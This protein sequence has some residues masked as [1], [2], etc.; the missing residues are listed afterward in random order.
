MLS[1]GDG[2]NRLTVGAGGYAN[3]VRGDNGDDTVT[4]T[5]DARI[6]LLKLDGGNN[7]VTTANGNIESYYSYGG[8]NTL[9]IGNGGMQQAVLSGDGGVHQVTATGFVGSLQVYDSGTTTAN[10]MGGGDHHCFGRG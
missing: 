2:N 4:L 5:G 8:N 6:L 1:M 10:I 9:N 3:V 7:V